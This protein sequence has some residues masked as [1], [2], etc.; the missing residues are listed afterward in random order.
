MFSPVRTGLLFLFFIAGVTASPG[1]VQAQG[2]DDNFVTV[3]PGVWTERE[4]PLV[5]AYLADNKAIAERGPVNI[6]ALISGMLPDDTPGIG[7]VVEATAEMVAYQNGKYDPENPLYHDADH[8]RRLGY[9]DMLVFPTFAAHDDT[10]MVPYP[11]AARDKL[12]VSQLNHSI[13]SYRPIYPGDTLFLVAN[14]RT[15]TDLTAPEGDTYRR[16]AISTKGSIYNQRGEKVNDVVFQVVESVRQYKE[17]RAP[18][19]AEESS[20]PGPPP[21]WIGPDWKSRPQHIYTDDDWNR[22]KDLWSN[23]KRQ[24]AEPLFWEDVT[25]GDRPTLTVDGPITASVSPEPPWGMGLGG[26]RT[27]KQEILSGSDNLVM[28][29]DGVYTTVDPAGHVPPVPGKDAAEPADDAPELEEGEIDTRDIHAQAADERAILINYLAR[30]I[31]IRHINSWMGDHGW[32]QNIR[33]GIMPV[34]AMAD[35]G[36]DVPRHPT[37]VSFLDKVPGMDGRYVNAH[38]MTSDLAIVR[39][40][41]YNK[42]WQDGELFVDL[43]LWVESIDGYIWW[44]GGATVRLPSK[45]TD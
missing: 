24:G 16:I 9:D 10:F 5:E 6:R 7:P 32:L 25:V 44:A 19:A 2:N 31:A 29:A 27:L 1:A 22:I 4:Q 30:D 45:R 36:Y 21:F 17:G 15:V 12:L 20:Q 39:S 43:A 41:V 33:W 13:T 11:G 3:Y 42:Y 35:V 18:A 26:S 34:E 8:A 40:Y 14:E 28:R 38:G 37:A 23:E